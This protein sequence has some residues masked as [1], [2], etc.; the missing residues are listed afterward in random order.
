MMLCPADTNNTPRGV[1]FVLRLVFEAFIMH[2][3]AQI[4]DLDLRLT[5]P[6]RVAIDVFGDKDHVALAYLET[7]AEIYVRSATL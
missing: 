6:F 1:L 7:F 5:V 3:A 4:Y 2:K